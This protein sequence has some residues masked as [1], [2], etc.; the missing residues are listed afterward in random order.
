MRNLPI[1]AALVAH[2]GHQ[3][4]P[5]TAGRSAGDCSYTD[6]KLGLTKDAAGFTWGLSYVDTDAKGGSGQCYRNAFGRDLGR[7][8]VVLT[9]AR[10]F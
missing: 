9:A 8:T 2:A 3:R 10:T 6:G 7:G 4:I 1:A 5:G